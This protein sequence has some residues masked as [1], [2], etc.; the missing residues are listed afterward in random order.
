[1]KLATEFRIHLRN[2][3]T[4]AERATQ[5]EHYAGLQASF[6]GELRSFRDDCAERLARMAAELGDVASV[7]QTMADHVNSQ[8][9]DL[10]VQVTKEI[11]RLEKA[12]ASN[13]LAVIQTE[14]K[15]AATGLRT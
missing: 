12:A 6:R 9:S 1:S 7:M 4:Q 10:E 15:I 13:D 3:Q 5:P 8:G 14:I 11:T 2:L